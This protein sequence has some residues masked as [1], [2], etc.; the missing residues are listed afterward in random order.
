MRLLTLASA[1]F[2]YLQDKDLGPTAIL[3]ERMLSD[4]P[5]KVAETALVRYL[6]TA[7]HFPTVA[8]IRE[9]AVAITQ[10]EKLTHNEAWHE[11]VK[12]I[13]CYGYY[14]EQEALDSMRPLTARVVQAMGWK[15][16]CIS[17]EPDVIRG[18]FRK[19]YEQT[20]NREKINAQVPQQVKE[21]AEKMT[22]RRIGG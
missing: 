22:A 21:L 6:S 18:Q 9:N 8:D 19:A 1:N 14:R 20:E 3:W 10:P 2:P 13:G 11:V 17:T 5:F 16:I 4:I 12:A 15:D 7:R